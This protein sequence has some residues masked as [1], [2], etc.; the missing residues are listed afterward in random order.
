VTAWLDSRRLAELYGLPQPKMSKILRLWLA[1]RPYQGHIASVTTQRGRGG[2]AG[3]V[4]LVAIDSL[5]AELRGRAPITAETQPAP[6]FKRRKR[7]DRDVR[8][9]DIGREWDAAVPFD[10][11]QRQRIAAE[12]RT[13]IRA[14]WASGAPSVRIACDFARKE[15]IKLTRAAGFDRAPA[16]MLRLCAVPAAFVS[17][18]RRA[19]A[20]IHTARS[21]AKRF[22]DQELPNVRRSRAHLLPMECVAGDVH[23][24]DILNRRDDG[25]LATVKMVTWADLANNRLFVTPFLLAKGEGICREHV[26]LSF[27]EM[28]AHPYWGLPGGLYLD[29]G[30][31]YNWSESLDD[32]LRLGRVRVAQRGPITRARPY[33]A[34][35]KVIESF[36]AALE[37]GPFAMLPGYIGGNRMKA[38]THNVG[39]APQPFPGS[40][41]DFRAAIGDAISFYHSRPQAGHLGGRSPVAAFNAVSG[42]QRT[43]IDAGALALAFA[44]VETRTIDKGTIHYEGSVFADDALLALGTGERVV[45]RA[46]LIGDAGRIAVFDETD[47]R[48]ICWARED[49]TFRFD[50]VA[51]ARE[52]ARRASV[53]RALLRDRA[54]ELPRLDLQAEMR[55]TAALTAPAILPASAGEV[56]L[57]EPIENAA[58]ALKAL[59]NAA[60][61]S[62]LDEEAARRARWRRA[63]RAV[64]E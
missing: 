36:F 31:E 57:A 41:G 35:A 6:G 52:Q 26:A 46:P 59:P 24:I 42:W 47:T 14:A 56:R 13:Y 5:P 32:I 10:Q 22:F 30:G 15:L 4:Y 37:R 58:R 61:R 49:A 29:N 2:R 17:A 60:P 43:D 63:K 50:D 11:A 1:G 38:K 7:S 16:E 18:E 62:L 40:D 48:F 19:Y 34:P 25:S 9:V 28:A 51:G 33:N 3:V 39:K 45:I 12:L 55:E 44:D 21:D 8:R 23:H 54:S 64:G 53:Q 20:L 27:A